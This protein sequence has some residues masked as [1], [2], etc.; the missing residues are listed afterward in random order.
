MMPTDA[1]RYSIRRL[2]QGDDLHDVVTLEAA[3]FTNPW[4]RD[5]LER[6]LRNVDVV[7]LY[8]LEDVDGRLIGFCGCWFVFDE[9]HINTLAVADQFRRRGHATRL[10]RFVLAEAAA[11]GITR[12]TLEVRRSNVAALRLY[13]Q[14]GF[15][16][17][18]VRPGYYTK[19][20]EDALVLWS[21]KLGFL[22]S[23]T[24]P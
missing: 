24:E 18:G 13:D 19:P 7:R 22:N 1:P 15:E 23:D 11:A 21:Q 4:S 3:A 20:V 6:D 14:F 16:V 8:V 5:T 17:R 12:A 9:L 2:H 10:L